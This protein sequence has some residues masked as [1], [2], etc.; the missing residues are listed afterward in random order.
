[1]KSIRR[2]SKSWAAIVAG[3]VAV[4]LGGFRSTAWSEDL[5]P[6]Q[7]VEQRISILERKLE[8]ADEAAATKAKEAAK[9]TADKDGFLLK[10]AD[11]TFGLKFSALVQA[12]GRFFIEDKTGTGVD[13][14][15]L[16]RVRPTFTGTLWKDF[17]FRI[18]PDFANNSA[19]S[20]YD[21]YID[22]KT[23]PVKL[24]VGKFKPPV[25]LER[26]QS[27]QDLAFVE[28]GYPTALVPSRD[29][30]LQLFGEVFGGKLGYQ[31][32]FTNGVADG[33]VG[34]TDAND[35]KEGAARVFATPFKDN[36]GLL[37]GLGVG[38]AGTYAGAQRTL[39]TYR[40]PG[41][42]T[43]FTPGGTATGDG[44]HYRISPQAYWYYGPFGS[45]AEY[46]QSSQ[47]TRVGTGPLNKIT[48]EAWQIYTTYV[49]TG[50][51]TSFKGVKP[52]NN[53]DPKAGGWGA[54]EVAGRFQRL[55][56][57]PDVYRLGIAAANTSIQRATAWSAGL[58][59]YLNRNLKFVADYEQTEFDKGA[60]TV[61][62]VLDRPTERIV[63]TRVQIAY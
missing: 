61:A 46:V 56:I 8:I 48:H 27:A 36:P 30:G 60:G 17:D 41:Q 20:L 32:S 63:F 38:I 10:S 45:L 57:D 58:N 14:F 34:E 5:P 23:F 6:P 19:T 44:E 40:T 33:A 62:R 39:A 3:F 51:E 21:A 13:Q 47:E 55:D 25:G 52:T 35:G 50:E 2:S 37:Q 16:R 43:A 7:S 31:A 22:V 42:L 59:W 24:R 53:F 54:W 9:T 15:L 1:M 28:R 18:T 49:L 29:T 4:T 11:G 12:D 26:L